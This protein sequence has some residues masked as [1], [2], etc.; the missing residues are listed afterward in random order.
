MQDT[1]HIR[2]KRIRHIVEEDRSNQHPHLQI[3][4]SLKDLVLL[5]MNVLHTSLVRL[6]ALNSNDTFTLC[7]KFCC[8]RRVWEDPPE[9]AAEADC[10]DS[11]L[12]YCQEVSG[13]GS[14]RL[15][16]MNIH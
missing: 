1:T 3:L 9:G 8:V 10:D 6:E 15:T 14:R 13:H 11:E 16:M 4:E 12:H 7:E 5:M 2:L